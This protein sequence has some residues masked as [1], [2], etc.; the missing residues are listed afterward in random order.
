M[1]T[2]TCSVLGCS[3]KTRSGR[4]L[5]C[6]MHYYR[7]RRKNSLSNPKRAKVKKNLFYNLTEDEAWILGLLW[8]DGYIRKNRVSLVSKDKEMLERVNKI[9][10]GCDLCLK[11]RKTGHWDWAFSDGVIADRLRKLGMFQNKSFNIKW[12]K[13]KLNLTWAFVRGL[14]DGDGCVVS[15]PLRTIVYSASESLAVSL[16]NWYKKNKISCSLCRQMSNK[17]NSYIYKITV[18]HSGSME[19][20]NLIYP[21]KKVPCLKRKRIKFEK[22]MRPIKKSGRKKES[23]PYKNIETKVIKHYLNIGKSHKKTG[24]AFGICDKTVMMILK[25]NKI[26]S[27]SGRCVYDRIEG[28]TKKLIIQSRSKGATFDEL[29]K[30]YGFSR[31]ILRKIIRSND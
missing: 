14:I 18:C 12:P 29:T 22:G 5:Y 24:C 7:L 1:T 6:E 13:I 9:S 27:Y 17:S 30:R 3:K 25:R 21:N 2:K 20:Y 19:L 23:S 8:A 16:L 26:K 31:N 15:N 4:A 10:G 11:Q 28:A